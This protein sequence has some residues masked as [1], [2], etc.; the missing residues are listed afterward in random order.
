MALS[1][2][3]EVSSEEMGR[4]VPK[5]SWQPST[6][7]LACCGPKGTVVLYSRSGKKIHEFSAPGTSMMQWND[8]FHTLALLNEEGT[9]V[10]YNN[11]TKKTETVDTG[12]KN[13]CFLSWS[14]YGSELVVGSRKG[15]YTLYNRAIQKKT[16]VSSAHSQPIIGGAW[17]STDNFVVMAGADRVVS[18][19]DTEGNVISSIPL[20]CDKAPLSFVLMESQGGVNSAD[21]CLGVVNTVDTIVAVNVETK[22]SFS[23]AFPSELGTIKSFCCGLDQSLCIAFSTGVVGLATLDASNMIRLVCEISLFKAAPVVVCVSKI[24]SL[25]AC[26]SDNAIKFMGRTRDVIYELKDLAVEVDGYYG[27]VD[28]MAW[29]PDEQH[30]TVA[31]HAGR[32]V[33]YAISVNNKSAICGNLVFYF[34]SN[35]VINIKNLRDNTVICSLTVDISPAIMAAGMGV[36]AIGTD[37][38][39]FYYSYY[40]PEGGDK[41][42]DDKMQHEDSNGES[43]LSGIKQTKEAV[44]CSLLSTM[45]YPSPI[46]DLKVS[47]E[48][49]AILVDG[50]AQLHSIRD[51]GPNSILL[52]PP[53][54][55]KIIAIGLSENFFMYITSTKVCVMT[56]QN[57]Q[58]VA[59]YTSRSTIKRAF[60]NPTCTRVV[61][62]GDNDTLYVLNPITEIAS[63]AEG[64]KGDHM[65]AIWDQ[66]DSTVFVTFGTNELITFVCSAHSRH[67]PTCESILV[68]DTAEDNLVTP[69][70]M[71]YQPIGLHRGVVVCQ[72]PGG[73]LD[74][75]QLQTH[76]EINSRSA[77]AQAFYNNFSLNRLRW[78]S[79][80]IS[81]PLEG[82]D[83]AVKALHL[84]DIDLAIC[85]YRQL[86]QPCMV[87]C[88]EKI[89]H[90]HEKNLLIG[91]VSMIL[92]FP[93]DAQNFFLRSSQP[94]CA[95]EMRRDLMHWEPA[96]LLAR[97]LA[98]DQVPIISKEYAQQLEYR[99]DYIKALEMYKNGHCVAPTGHASAEL[100]A[101]QDAAEAHNQE[102]LE[103]TARCYVHS[104]STAEGV[105]IALK[106]ENKEFINTCA[107]LCEEERKFD[108]AAQ[109]Y[110]KA[111]DTERAAALYIEKSKNLKAAGRLLPLIQSRNIIGIYAAA[112]EREGQYK[113]AAEAYAQ[114][115]DWENS[116]RLKVEKLNDLT[117]AYDVVRKTKSADAAA[118]VANMCKKK[119]DYN[120]AVE[121]LVLCSSLPEAFELAK[122]HNLMFSYESALLKQ[123]PLKDGIAPPSFQ[124]E[125]G[126]IALY[127]DRQGR[128]GQAGLFYTIAA[129][130]PKALQKF[131]EAGEPEDIDKAVEVVGKARSESLTN[132]LIDFLMG[133]ADGEAKD[134]SYIF[135]LYMSLGSFEKAAKTSA[136][137]AVKEQEIG[138]Y[139]LAHKT[140]VEASHMLRERNMRVPNDL[141]RCFMLLHSYI[142]VKDVITLLKDEATGTRL[143]LRVARNIQKFPKHMS[144]ILCCTVTQCSRA[145]FKKS[146][147]DF[148]C[149][150][151]QQ[152]KYR[153]GLPE[154]ERKRIEGI[155]RK[156]GKDELVD[157]V[158][159]ASPCPFCDAPVLDTE[160][161]CGSC[162]NMLP[163]CVVTGKHA[164]K[165]DFTLTPCCGFPA[166]YSSLILRLKS[167]STCPA[168]TALLDINKIERKADF[169]FRVFQ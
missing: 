93:K 136:I 71:Q 34:V 78:A 87:M 28:S 110:E 134:P 22:E 31:T 124:K 162:K 17:T 73:T 94:L 23:S 50:Q 37:S 16:A 112:K 150:L 154:K 4:G 114:A 54:E 132:K 38:K 111:G 62:I 52:P 126:M 95:L 153:L 97:D 29:S 127:Y 3:I 99:G 46:A 144:E 135:K 92:G 43:N 84:L 75:V 10:L 56:V 19:S 5:F 60:P 164:I 122:E 108:E 96:L 66:A 67:G 98:E 131:M 167:S 133:E 129:N 51:P 120:S 121:F 140:V 69:L 165:A 138:N 169:D 7:I 163:L 85:V 11:K 103:G 45:E 105:E 36:L 40:V 25:Y 35:K 59:E 146:A 48:Y 49:A 77:N 145:G 148:A 72:T 107:K 151:I 147:F 90:I 21:L 159:N 58:V 100:T 109:L 156:S 118:L 57:K 18:V 64:Y 63:P 137:I 9:V 168:C 6:G 142:I 91:H 89:K 130:F 47:S 123:V 13:L 74:M 55:S 30:L 61:L 101:A 24:N 12:M 80:N 119:G 76:A 143:L 149:F 88:L 41:G 79:Q 128:H 125:F 86:T 68:R 32:V 27:V 152:E 141:R 158:E 104:G 157:P 8:L 117:G 115:E 102:C 155:V 39:V 83:L 44:N 42:V 82:E 166:T 106:S 20:P 14:P 2:A 160:L 113:D 1:K 81:T 53:S 65:D 33:S 161:D 70:P 26:I 15:G 139:R 116:V